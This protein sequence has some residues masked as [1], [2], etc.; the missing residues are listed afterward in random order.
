MNRFG[1]VVIVIVGLCAA[2]LVA[3]SSWNIPA[4]TVAINKVVPD[5]NLPQ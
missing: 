2:G 5:E 4:P 3:L 1:I